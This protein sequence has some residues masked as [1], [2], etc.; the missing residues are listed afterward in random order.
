MNW[1]FLRQARSAALIGAAALALTACGST[2]T[3]RSGKDISDTGKVFAGSMQTIGDLA[4]ERVIDRS[5]AGLA[6]D[7]AA[8]WGRKTS[9][10]FAEGLTNDR[11]AVA[12]VLHGIALGQ[13]HSAKLE[14]Y[15]DALAALVN[16]PTKETYVAATGELA[17]S[18]ETL[19][20]TL[21][22]RNIVTSAHLAAAQKDAIGTLGGII[23]QQMQ[24]SR[25]RDVL[26]RDAK[27]IDD[28][29]RMQRALLQKYG[30]L[31]ASVDELAADA[32][33]REKVRDPFVK[34]NPSAGPPRPPAP[35][36]PADW[37]AN[38]GA[39]VKRQLVIAEVENAKKALEKL[40]QEWRDFAAGKQ[41]RS[42]SLGDWMVISDSLKQ[43][44]KV[45]ENR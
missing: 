40:R 11:A 25:V 8:G 35:A 22:S 33:F 28:Q 4:A 42:D 16:D 26:Q 17:A 37:R 29:V 45:H 20:T 36:L 13:A 5:A 10:E 12:K 19:A 6:K 21:E 43:I 2:A 18:A 44:Q 38:Y 39:D 1:T 27:T 7:R 23:G 30:D 24:A 3:L 31:I 32:F 14:A 15:F 9:A 41:T 34:D